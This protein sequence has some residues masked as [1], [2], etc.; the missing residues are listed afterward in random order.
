MKIMGKSD[1]DGDSY[2]LPDLPGK[3]RDDDSPPS[4]SASSTK[5]S[6]KSKVANGSDHFDEVDLVL[7]IPRDNDF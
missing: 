7:R 2:A 6:K 1:R 5:M 4:S 3:V